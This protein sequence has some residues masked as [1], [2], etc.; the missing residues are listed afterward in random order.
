MPSC[1]PTSS[2][3]TST[4]SAMSSL[5]LSL[6]FNRNNKCYPSS[7][8]PP[9]H[10]CADEGQTQQL[11]QRTYLPGD[12]PSL[13]SYAIAAPPRPLG[14]SEPFPVS[15]SLT[16]K[17]GVVPTKIQTSIKRVIE[18]FEVVPTQ[19]STHGR[20]SGSPSSSP[21]F[22]P[23]SSGP[24]TGTAAPAAVGSGATTDEDDSTPVS[25]SDP[26]DKKEGSGARLIRVPFSSSSSSSSSVSSSKG[27]E[28]QAGSE[29]RGGKVK[30]CRQTL[31]SMTSFVRRSVSGDG[32]GGGSELDTFKH[33]VM[34]QIP[35]QKSSSHWAVGCT[36]KTGMVS[37][38]F[39]LS[40]KVCCHCPF[41]FIVLVFL[42]GI[43][44]LSGFCLRY[45]SF[46][47]MVEALPTL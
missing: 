25:D 5:S 17:P 10:R 33:E 37:V 1:T 28:K 46:L 21:V 11:L 14:P 40:A 34:V 44:F 2:S 20:T 16:C 24:G 7:S 36:M 8:L 38:R 42:I 43:F 45:R 9:A 31:C 15:Y 3:L 22:V 35:E 23:L 41:S 19:K 30:S 32:G 18:L 47:R 27:K 12:H 29:S 26:E 39:V 4:M 13:S 6:P